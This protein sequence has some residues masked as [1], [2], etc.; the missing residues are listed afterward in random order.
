MPNHSS[1]VITGGSSGIGLAAAKK[2]AHRFK[3]V[4]LIDIQKPMEAIDNAVFIECDVS[5]M[6]SVEQAVKK[7]D[8]PLYGLFSAAGVLESNRLEMTSVERIHEV[9]DINLK[10]TLFI[11]KAFL[12]IFQAQG[13]GNIVLCGSD[14]SF[15]GKSGNSLYGAT[16]AAIAQLC[17]AMAV[18]N[19][20][21]NIRVNCV[22][23]GTIDTPL[24][25]A[26]IQRHAKKVGISIDDVVDALSKEQPIQ[27]IGT[28]EEVAELVGFL[29]SDQ[30]SF[31]TGSLIPIDGGYTAQ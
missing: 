14:Q 18:E 19:A 7:I 29:M 16:K 30:A 6:P 13:H 17:K 15:V 12:P 25:Q 10:G 20:E 9:V 2:L 21:F 24:Y 4:Y 27:R 5:D 3:T 22:C 31:M 8:A 23:P 28:A 11:L 26:A 1:I